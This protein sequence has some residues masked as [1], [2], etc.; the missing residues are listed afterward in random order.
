MTTDR[1]SSQKLTTLNEIRVA[2]AA[3][4]SLLGRRGTSRDRRRA[5]YTLTLTRSKSAAVYW[6]GRMVGPP[7]SWSI[8][9]EEVI[10][11]L[12]VRQFAARKRSISPPA[13][14]GALMRPPGDTR[15]PPVSG[16][17]RSNR[18]PADTARP[19]PNIFT[20][21]ACNQRVRSN[22]GSASPLHFVWSPSRNVMASSS[23]RTASSMGITGRA[24]NTN[25]GNIEQN[26]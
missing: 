3:G 18:P 13:E 26:L 15:S 24:S 25:A 22:A 14:T 17:D 6:C 16:A 7:S 10:L 19:A 2:D 4:Q 8:R 21:Y 20:S 12:P 11:L 1:P 5:R 9:D 23:T